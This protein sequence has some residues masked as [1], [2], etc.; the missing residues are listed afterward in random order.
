VILIIK[1]INESGIER[2]YIVSFRKILQ[3]FGYFLIVTLVSE[4]NFPHVEGSNSGNGIT[5]VHN[6]RSLSLRLREQDVDEFF[7]RRDRP[8]LF[9]IIVHMNMI[10]NT[11][12]ISLN[13]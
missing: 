6:C 11:Y 2:M 13:I 8:D 1:N 9:E 12:K 3:Y 5:R 4:L 10:Y 7:R